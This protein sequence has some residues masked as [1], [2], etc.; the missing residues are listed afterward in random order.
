VIAFSTQTCVQ[1]KRLQTPALHTLQAELGDAVR[2]VHV[3]AIERDDLA[4]TYKILTV[5]ATVVLTPEGR[6][7]A[8]NDGFAPA[9]RLR[10]QITQALSS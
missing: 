1:C 6:V 7:A 5:P 4:S 8:L 9:A 2:I 3:D 10:Q